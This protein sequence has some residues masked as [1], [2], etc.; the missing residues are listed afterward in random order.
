MHYKAKKIDI[1]ACALIWNFTFFESNLWKNRRTFFIIF[2]TVI[3]FERLH[4]VSVERCSAKERWKNNILNRL[5]R[6]SYWFR[7]N[8]KNFYDSFSRSSSWCN[9]SIGALKGEVLKAGLFKE[10]WSCS[11]IKFSKWWRNVN[12]Q[13]ISR[14]HLI[15][16][17][18]KKFKIKIKYFYL[19]TCLFEHSIKTESYFTKSYRLKKLGK[20]S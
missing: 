3:R 10:G 19:S 1:S 17:W 9:L 15:Y 6:P 2:S 8:W 14:K 12:S 18:K 13:K 5:D 16:L 20:F 7:Y 4:M 11:R